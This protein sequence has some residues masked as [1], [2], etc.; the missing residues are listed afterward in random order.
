MGA[1]LPDWLGLYK[2][3]INSTKLFT[4]VGIPCFPVQLSSLDKLGIFMSSWSYLYLQESYVVGEVNYTE[5]F[6]FHQYSLL[7]STIDL[8]VVKF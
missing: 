8:H 6:P 3:D 7:S 2:L 5:L 1:L 4:Y